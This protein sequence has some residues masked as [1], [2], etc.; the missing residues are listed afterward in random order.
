MRGRPDSS[1]V[2]DA[3]CYHPTG[4]S[5][6]SWEMAV[7]ISPYKCVKD[8]LVWEFLFQQSNERKAEDLTYSLSLMVNLEDKNHRII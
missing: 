3:G 8:T 5:V 6:G 4:S 1:R 7:G 2:S